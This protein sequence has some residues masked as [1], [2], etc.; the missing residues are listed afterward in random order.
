MSCFLK[1]SCYCTFNDFPNGL[2]FALINICGIFLLICL[3]SVFDIPLALLVCNH[4]QK[5]LIDFPREHFTTPSRQ[6]GSITKP[7]EPKLKTCTT[8]FNIHIYYLSRRFF[9]AR[10]SALFA[11]QKILSLYDSSL[12]EAFYS[13]FIFHCLMNVLQYCLG[14]QKLLFLIKRAQKYLLTKN[15]MLL[16]FGILLWAHKTPQPVTET[17]SIQ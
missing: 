8:S 7:H 12:N 10:I 9:H 3:L 14:E 2:W 17:H 16:S 4:L 13:E 1:I 5:E 11:V 15:T 6:F